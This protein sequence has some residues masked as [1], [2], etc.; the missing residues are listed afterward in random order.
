[1]MKAIE[2][3]QRLGL[4]LSGG[5]FRAS[6]Y[7]IGVLARM[8]E[9]GMLK[10]VESLSTVSGGSIVGAAYYLLLK[11][12]LESKTDHEITDSDYI[13]I[14]Q[15]L[16]K[17]FLS[18]IQ[19]NLRMR[20]FANPLK[21][22][23][24][25][26]PNYSRSDTIGELYE[27]YIYRPLINAGNRRIRMSDLLI[28]PKGVKQPF[29][30]WDAVNGNPKRKHKVPVLMINATSLNSGHNWYFTAMSMGE[31]PPRD[32]TFRDIDK[33]DRYR[34]MNYDEID[35]A[36]TGR[37]PYFLLGNAVAASAGVPGLFPPMAISNLYKDRRVQLVDGGV[38]DNQGVASLLDPDCVCSDFILSDASGQIEAINKPRTDLLP[39][40]SLTTSI[41]LRRVREE[42][43][44]NLIKTRGKRVAYFHLTRGLSA[45]K[46]DWAPSDKIEIEADSLTS[47]FDVSEEAQRAL[48][49]IRTDLD[50][51]T[52]VE[53]GCLEADGYQMS[54][55]EL[56]KLKPYVSSQPLQA[57]WQ[58]SQYQPM[59]KAGDPEILNQLEQGRYRIFKPLMYVIKGATGMMQSLGLILVSLPVML[60]LVLIFFLVHYFLESML[61]INIWKIIS[62][63]KSFQQ[64]MFDMAP[65]LYLFLVVVILSKI[66]DLLLKGTGK[67]ITI[68][69]KIL[70]SPM[71]FITGLFTRLIFPLIFAI[72]III[73]LHTVDRYFIRTMGK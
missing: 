59:L 2:S 28:Q 5:G 14:V 22:I 17:H 32:L 50:S 33:K 55:P 10:H 41:L 8:A 13:E 57:N 73:Y 53:A 30:P 29:H 52:D 60:S 45:R 18:A 68:F 54:K 58:F 46:I 23:R 36:S 63:P 38:Y 71:K 25:S 66:A 9:F 19:K 64:F 48:S 40:L 56:L 26:M 62:D 51:F 16:E 20:T 15:K 69:Y 61:D 24:M 1:M 35:E 65:A 67:W 42:V 21:N 6:F 4:A 44:N 34:R 37:K 43:V 49:K 3:N 72:P 7:H 12:L 39:I 70:K 31:V 47:Q 27:Y 11:D